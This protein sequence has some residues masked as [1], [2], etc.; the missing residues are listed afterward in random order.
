MTWVFSVGRYIYGAWIDARD[1][2]VTL[3]RVSPQWLHQHRQS[4]HAHCPRVT[5]MWKF[6]MRP[7]T[8]TGKRCGSVSDAATPDAPDT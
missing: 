8:D 4:Y 5:D 7:P 2:L 1:P 6:K 3:G